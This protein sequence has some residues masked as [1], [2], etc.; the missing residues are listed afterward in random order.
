M[1]PIQRTLIRE[2]NI[3]HNSTIISRP[4]T[5]KVTKLRLCST[6]TVFMYVSR[7]NDQRGITIVECVEAYYQRIIRISGVENSCPIALKLKS[8]IVLST[9]LKPEWLQKI[10]STL[11]WRP[12]ITPRI[13]ITKSR[14]TYNTIKTHYL[15]NQLATS[16]MLVTGLDCR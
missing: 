7:I 1:K 15:P 10:H 6:R 12:N 3:R 4:K 2:E 16:P 11:C 13:N 8:R 14:K 5:E 9:A